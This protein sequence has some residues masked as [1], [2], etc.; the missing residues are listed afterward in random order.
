[1]ENIM[2]VNEMKNGNKKNVRTLLATVLLGGM[3]ICSLLAGCGNKRKVIEETAVGTVNKIIEENLGKGN[4]AKCINVTIK[5]EPSK[6]FY[7]A[8][9]LLDTGVELKI[10]IEVK[11]DKAIRVIIPNQ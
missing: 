7:I 1:M 10:T 9:A 11:G 5:E 8:T 3:L 2:K 6:N 4:G